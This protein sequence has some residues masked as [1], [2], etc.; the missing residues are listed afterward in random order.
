[1]SQETNNETN[2]KPV[3]D[4]GIKL[5]DGSDYVVWTRML[6]STL[7]YNKLAT[8]VPVNGGTPR[9]TF[10]DN[11]P[12]TK[13]Y[14]LRN[15]SR[16]RMQ[17]VTYKTTATEMWEYFYEAYGGK[18]FVRMF[19]G[20]TNL[21]HLD[22]QITA[23]I[24]SSLTSLTHAVRQ[25]EEAANSREISIEHL[26]LIM[27]LS[28]L[29]G[30]YQ[31]SIAHLN[32][33][34]VKTISG[35]QAELVHMESLLNVSEAS[36]PKA[37][38]S[39][40]R[41]KSNPRKKVWP[42]GTTL[43][44]A[45]GWEENSCHYC[46]VELHPDTCSDCN[47]KGHRTSNSFKCPK[48]ANY[49]GPKFGAVA[50]HFVTDDDELT[51]FAGK[52]FGGMVYSNPITLANRLGPNPNAPLNDR[53]GPK[54]SQSGA[55]KRKS[56][57]VT[58]IDSKTRVSKKTKSIFNNNS[59]KSVDLALVLDSGANVDI[60]NNKNILVNY[61]MTSTQIGTAE[62]KQNINCIGQG[63]LNLNSKISLN[64]AY[65]CPNAAMNLLSVFQLTKLGLIVTFDNVK[66]AVTRKG[67]TVL[68]GIQENG[69][70]VYR[71]TSHALAFLAAHK[72]STRMDLFHARMGHINY[73]DL[74][75]LVHMSY[76]I[77][78]DNDPETELCKSCI[79]AKSHRRHF[80][81]SS[82]HAKH[83]GELTHVDICYVGVE[84]INGS[85]TQFILFTDDHSRHIKCYLIKHKSEA[86]QCLKHYDSIV[87]NQTGSHCQY[88]RSDNA[89][90][91]FSNATKQY[92][93]QNGIIQQSSNDYSPQGN[94]RAERPN[95]TCL[96]GTSAM[97]HFMDLPYEMWGYALLCFVYLKNRSPHSALCKR[98]PFEARFQKLPDLSNIR[99]FGCKAYMHIP[100]EKRKG[101]GSKLFDKAHELI[102]VGYSERSNSWLLLD[103][104]NH[105]EYRSDEVLFDE[106]YESVTRTKK[107]LTE[108]L[109]IAGS[110]DT[111]NADANPNVNANNSL[112]D[113]QTGEFNN[114]NESS[115]DGVS[116]SIPIDN[117]VDHGIGRDHSS[118]TPDLGVNDDSSYDD[119]NQSIDEEDIYPLTAIAVHNPITALAMAEATEPES[120]ES[121]DK[122]LYALITESIADNDNPTYHQAMNG[123]DKDRFIQ[124]I[125]DEYK[126]LMDNKVFSEPMYLPK[127]SRTL[128]TKMV[129][130]LK[131]AEFKNAVRRAKARL[132]ARGFN[133][134]QGIDFFETFSP[135]AS[136]DALRMFLTIMATL[137]YEIDCV[138]VITAFLLADLQEEIYIEIPDGY[139]DKQRFDGKVLRLLKNLYG[140]KQA[141]MEWNATIDKYLKSLGF[142]PIQSDRCIYV[143][144]FNGETCYILL[145][146]DD[147]LIASK[148][149][150]TMQGLKDAVHQKFPIKDKGP[151]TFFLNM[152]IHRD[153]K[154][155]TITLHQQPK[156][157]KLLSDHRLSPEEKKQV[158]KV[159]KIPASPEIF[160][161]A[162]QCPENQDDANAFNRTQFQSFVG[163]LLYIAITARP[164][165]ST[166]ISSVAR[167]SHNPGK[168][169]WRAV[170]L[171][172]RYLQG[173]VNMRLVLGGTKEYPEVEAMV[174]S[175][176]A[177]DK[178]RR[179]RTGFIIFLL[180]SPIIW[181]SKLQK[182]IAL[183][184]TE[185]EYVALATVARFVIWARQF[186][187]EL[188]F[189]QT[190]PTKIWE[191]NKGCID[192]AISSKSHPSVKHIDI[193]HHFIRERVQ[194]I[195]DIKLYKIGTDAMV[196]D[197]FTKQLAFPIFKRHRDNLKLL[198]N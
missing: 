148:N 11:D 73:A 149:R 152:H 37:Y 102:F 83:F 17:D 114:S 2:N 35:A 183:S 133:Q 122:V 50:N 144:T 67:E 66:C 111:A 172:L 95:R 63:T 62:S 179:S 174:D 80:A 64:D 134:V 124:A 81:S 126:S 119:T 146:V 112:S 137:D 43:C 8:I 82:S 90:E 9:I 27:F 68:I 106:E 28:K 77:I 101:A 116:T 154:A 91:F 1:M 99:I 52:K 78:L 171:I 41:M 195:K 123:P 10:K 193:R 22:P 180:G 76:G 32:R 173:T 29:P 187:L 12:R 142:Q 86:F 44:K 24:R 42:S 188:G 40:K 39:N 147:M 158:A 151:V 65:H 30:E 98:T 79:M 26:G 162:E 15:L 23:G 70:Y 184:S 36:D 45:H 120:N 51:P 31:S 85:C 189:E 138:D 115:L 104:D 56:L 105:Q 161:S 113:D 97:L 168:A 190:E 16:E 128:D 6:L 88:L 57:M 191:D 84:T 170:L 196:A 182:C 25:T 4:I 109:Q 136:L 165:I 107:Q 131:E 46:H 108:I 159:S 103:P 178:S 163:M 20:I 14:I 181:S 125:E 145:Y 71:P 186:L 177:G 132:C 164:D 167:F 38:F 197:I 130:K 127:G 135:V 49:K 198:Q 92:C 143:G 121:F 87:F 61:R 194:D 18:S 140:L 7:E 60:V 129:L 3:F 33:N 185:A 19:N 74:R 48:N 153:R 72:Q 175:D 176:W 192:I 21:I 156:I 169:H 13:L 55:R 155:R 157:E 160:L 59:S 166:A 69:L 96:E 100:K 150:A 117:D 58:K 75:R 47:K 93:N 54:E 139:P 34:N 53:L 110:T 141:P 118:N 94:A 5:K 89:K